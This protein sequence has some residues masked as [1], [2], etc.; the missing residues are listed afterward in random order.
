M[1]KTQRANYADGV[2]GL[3]LYLRQTSFFFSFLAFV[4]MV[5]CALAEVFLARSALCQNDSASTFWSLAAP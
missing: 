1:L 5:L 3:L 4:S 2:G